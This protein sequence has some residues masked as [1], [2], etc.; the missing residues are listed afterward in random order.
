MNRPSARRHR[1]CEILEPRRERV[2]RGLVAL[3]TP[4]SGG[5]PAYRRDS[6]GVCRALTSV[7]L[8][9]VAAGV[10]RLD[11]AKTIFNRKITEKPVA[12]RRSPLTLNFFCQRNDAAFVVY[13]ERTGRSFSECLRI[14][15]SAAKNV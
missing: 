4:E 15:S 8:P 7:G 12:H 9:L 13:I 2:D 6:D 5:F 14:R 10:I 3:F 11:H 1:E